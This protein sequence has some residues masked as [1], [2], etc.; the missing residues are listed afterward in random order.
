MKDV[1]IF[2]GMTRDVCRTPIFSLRQWVMWACFSKS[3][4]SLFASPFSGIDGRNF[5]RGL[6]FG[7]S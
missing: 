6:R 2:W 1:L 3:G 5:D 7:L 4:I